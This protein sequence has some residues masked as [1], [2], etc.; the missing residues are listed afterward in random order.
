MEEGQ[1]CC[2]CFC[3][4]IFLVSII[5]FAASFDTLD[6]HQV[7]IKY[8]NN[9]K[10]IDEKRIYNNGRYFLGLGLAFIEFPIECQLVQFRG[11]KSLRMWSL[12]GQLVTVELSLMYR[13]ERAKVIHIYKRYEEDFKSRIVQIVIRTAK[14]VSIQY[15]ATEFFII[16]RT[17]GEHMRA[18]M[19]RRLA[20][21][22][23]TLELFNLREIKI[24]LLFENKIISKQSWEQKRKTQGW[25]NQ[26]AVKRADITVIQGKVQAEIV[27][28]KTKARAER[29]Q[30]I[31]KARADALEKITKQE[32]MSYNKMQTELGLPGT[33]ILQFKYGQLM[34]KLEQAVSKRN[35]QFIIGV[36]ETA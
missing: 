11:R 18:E 27:Y 9:L 33:R 32:A 14:K 17:I 7:A 19:R 23:V 26:T 35:L 10:R 30:D 4:V 20:K 31:E 29:D 5:L 6:P 36:N 28:L 3:G 21:E 12:E 25:M 34:W 24:P 2:Y 8:N 15:T 13:L 1:K 22:W 16:R